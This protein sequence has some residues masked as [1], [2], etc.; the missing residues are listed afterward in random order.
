MSGFLLSNGIELDNFLK[1][2]FE[3]LLVCIHLSGRCRKAY[4]W[5]NEE[6]RNRVLHHFI[7]EERK[8]LNVSWMCIKQERKKKKR[9]NLGCIWLLIFKREQF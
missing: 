3:E 2:E 8:D 9:G 7:I 5:W 4:G 6:Y 1:G